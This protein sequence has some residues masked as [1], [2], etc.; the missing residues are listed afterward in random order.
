[1]TRHVHQQGHS[2]VA[3]A[4]AKI[5]AKY[6][7]LKA[8]KLSKSIKFKCG[9]CKEMAHETETQLMANLPALR[10][11][12]YT[13]PF[14]YTACDHFGPYSVKV[15][16]NKTAKHYGVVFTCLNT[17]AVHVEMAVDC[18]TMEF[19]QVL[20]RFFAIRGQPAVMISDNGSQFVGAERE[21]GEM[22]REVANL[23]NQRPIGRIPNDPDNG[24]Y[25]YPYDIL[26]GRASSEVPQGPF[27]ETQNPRHRVEF[28][29]K[30]VDSFWKR[31]NRDVFPS[32]VPRKQWQIER[33]NVKVND[34]V[35]VAD[36]NAVRGKWCTGRIM[37][38]YP[39]PDGRVRNVK[40][41]TST[42]VYS[43][44]VTKISVI[45]PAEE[46]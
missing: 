15:G 8:M 34:I 36:S 44:P 11:A 1:M 25:I 28:L 10:L 46:E 4:T 14:Y 42:G 18:S 35:T 38:V 2:G 40:I 27:K 17:R 39:G 37:E 31:W 30:I 12:P 7:I 13:P 16:R 26:L 32:L 5:R 23:V 45:C 20:R 41:K 6:W 22:V 19:L 29:Q 3:A 21:L 24:K 43:R 33:R 9:F